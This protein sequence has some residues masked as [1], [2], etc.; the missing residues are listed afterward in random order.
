MAAIAFVRAKT[1]D[2]RIVHDRMVWLDV[3]SD[4]LRWQWQRSHDGG[5]SWDLTWEIDYRRIER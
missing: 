1:V 4:S 3:T 5:A 2:D